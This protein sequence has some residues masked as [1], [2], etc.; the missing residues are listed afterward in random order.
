MRHT[1]LLPSHAQL[2]EP[3]AAARAASAALAAQIRTEIIAAG[4]AISFARY[5]ELALYTPGLGYYSGGAQKFGAAGDFITAPELSPLFGRALAQQVAQV[6][7]ASAPRILE[8]G[9]GSGKLAADLLLEMERLGAPC[10]RYAILELSGELRARQRETISA[11]APHLCSKVEWLDTLPNTIEGCVIANEVLD[12]MPVHLI[13]W[14]DSGAT[15]QMVSA[16]EAGFAFTEREL[17]ATLKADAEQIAREH[18]LPN[19]YTSEL[20]PVACALTRELAQRLTC[21]AAVL[22]DYGFAANEYYHPQRATGTLKAH[23]RHH[24]LDDPFFWPG[25]SDLTAHVDFSAIAL[26]AQDAGLNV[27]GYTTQAQFLINCGITQL[28]AHATAPDKAD[29]EGGMT[30]AKRYLAQSNAVQR[31]L[32]PAEMGELFKVLAVSK[33]LDGELLGFSNGNQVHKL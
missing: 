5:M 25:L 14:R 1:T 30:A 7:A 3:D 8:F 10:E 21:G 29:K 15:E 28:L 26:A 11:L 20:G 32:S 13:T 24:A 18:T 16:T 33:G 22:I 27:E 23:Y 9:A 6:C 2:P 17:N 4:G 12:A 19:G 31:L